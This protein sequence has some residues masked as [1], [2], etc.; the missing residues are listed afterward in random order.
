VACIEVVDFDAQVRVPDVVV[1]ERQRRAAGRVVLDELE[2]EVREP[3]HRDLDVGT[4]V[5][6]E[7]VEPLA[8]D[9]S[10][11]TDFE[12][13]DVAVERERGVE[14]RDRDAHVVQADHDGRLQSASEPRQK[15]RSGPS[16]VAVWADRECPAAWCTSSPRICA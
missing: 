13:D 12:A 3:Q 8:A 6:G 10:P 15:G 11:Q 1:R 14:V 9:S 2:C 5:A 4:L 16:T 7:Q